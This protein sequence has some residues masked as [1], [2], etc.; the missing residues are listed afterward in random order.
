[1]QK[2]LNTATLFPNIYYAHLG[3]TKPHLLFKVF[4]YLFFISST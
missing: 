3:P 2:K 1:M 4:I